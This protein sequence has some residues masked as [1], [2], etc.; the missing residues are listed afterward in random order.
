MHWKNNMNNKYDKL[1]YKAVIFDMDGTMFDTEYLASIA[2]KR[3]GEE[4]NYTITEDVLSQVRGRNITDAIRIFS[5]FYGTD[6]VYK[7]AKVLR[8][9]YVANMI[10]QD[11]VPIKK[12]LLELL[13]FLKGR[14][15]KMAVATSSKCEPAKRHLIETGV[16]DYFHAHI[17]GDMVKISKPNPEIF[18]IAAEQLGVTPDECLVLEDSKAGIRA[19]KNAGMCP[20]LIPDL[21]PP[22]KEMTEDAYLICNDLL[23]V[24]DI[25]KNIIE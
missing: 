6:Q 22:D 16:Y 13:T 12:G 18:L 15:K 7:R 20:I 8:D 4:L 11:G 21:T 25:L 1:K 3:A 24:L 2:W 10:E 9:Q 23:E 14:H 5:D 19:G 17:Y